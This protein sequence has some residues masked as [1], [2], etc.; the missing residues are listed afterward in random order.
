MMKNRISIQLYDADITDL[1]NGWDADIVLPRS[2]PDH[3]GVFEDLQEQEL[4]YAI[5]QRNYPR[6]Y[7]LL[8]KLKQPLSP[9]DA[10]AACLCALAGTPRLMNTLLDHCPPISEFQFQGVGLT[11]SLVNV[12]VRHD[13]NKMLDILL[14]RGADPNGGPIPLTAKTPIEEAFCSTAYSCLKRLLE[15]PDLSIPLTEPMLNTWGAQT[16]D[17]DS[18]LFFNP[19]GLWCCQLLLERLTGETGSLFD[20]L[21][22]PSQLRL[23][24][25]LYHAN[26]ELAAKIC[27]VRP[28]TDE[29]A[30]EV[31]AHYAADRLDCSLFGGSDSK[32]DLL[33]MKRAQEIQFLCQF[34]CQR[35]DLLQTPQLRAA[36]ALAALAMPE[37][38]PFLARWIQ[39]ME[40][41]PVLLPALP[42]RFGS[43]HIPYQSFP[44][45]NVASEVEDEFF[46]RWE[47]RLGPRLIPA[48]DIN[49]PTMR[50][51]APHS[52]R[53]V[54]QQVHFVGTPPTDALSTAAAQMLLHAPEDM[55]PQLLQPCGLLAQEQPQ[56]L[57]DACQDLP[58]VR[59][60]LILPYLRK[61]ADYRL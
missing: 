59:R 54:L 9:T 57:L 56:L 13:K 27:D 7:S 51:L 37:E 2:T 3:L 48:M 53:Q 5:Y 42:C 14:S 18:S 24:H 25:A 6:A 40:D 10:A 29:D 39:Q 32:G 20:P 23:G 55:L 28:L 43:Y 34:F 30:D 44:V 52:L 26:Y 49:A 4:I 47:A 61:T 38:D 33:Y 41:G 12:A 31:L 46:A 15:I 22:V 58:P 36:V 11:A 19:C 35:P 17:S 8:R 16:T 1:L 50:E 60:N 45:W 21:P